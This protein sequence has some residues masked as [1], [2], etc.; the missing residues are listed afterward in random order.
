MGIMTFRVAIQNA[1]QDL[2]RLLCSHPAYFRGAWQASLHLW[3]FQESYFL[4]ISVQENGTSA[5]ILRL[6]AVGSLF[7]RF[8]AGDAGISV[9]RADLLFRAFINDPARC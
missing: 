3:F 8:V 7:D 6:P 1:G 2:I 5:A 4:L 9:K